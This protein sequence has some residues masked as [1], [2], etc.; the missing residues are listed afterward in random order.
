MQCGK[1]LKIIIQIN[2]PC[3]SDSHPSAVSQQCRIR[4]NNF[5]H[6]ET[7]HGAEASTQRTVALANKECHIWKF[8]ILGLDIMKTTWQ[9]SNMPV[10]CWLMVV[11]GVY[12]EKNQI[13][14]HLMFFCTNLKRMWHVLMKLYVACIV[15]LPIPVIDAVPNVLVR[16][17][18]EITWY[19]FTTSEHAK[20]ILPTNI[21]QFIPD[22]FP[23]L[24]KK[25]VIF[26]V[27]FVSLGTFWPQL[28][29]ALPALASL[30]HHR[31]H[32]R[33]TW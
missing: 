6:R 2:H 18:L 23:F 28:S 13:S 26:A 17:Y 12:N 8:C 15:K 27:P 14:H 32:K 33:P 19:Y 20:W 10:W 21:Y 30:H 3:K 24:K 7:K 4:C 31:F 29:Y 11:W 22:G 1:S 25:T 9:M 5:H 16:W